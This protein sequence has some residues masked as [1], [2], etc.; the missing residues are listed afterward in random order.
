[1]KILLAYD[2]SP[3]SGR[4]L[5]EAVQLCDKLRAD[6]VALRVVEGMGS[7]PTGAPSD[8]IPADYLTTEAQA[9]FARARERAEAAGCRVLTL[10][11]QGP[12]AEE[13]LDCAAELG[14]AYIVLGSTGKS[15]VKKF[16][17]G[18]V[19]SAVAENADC[20]VILVK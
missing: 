17:L 16:L 4:A 12:P 6:L 14:A 3:A 13:I 9:L 20:S 19:C 18:S 8:D 7:E 1:M 10:L 2:G 11:R 15:G 5:E